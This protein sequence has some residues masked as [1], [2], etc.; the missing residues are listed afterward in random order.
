LWIFRDQTGLSFTPALWS[1][2]QEALDGS[3]YFVLMASPEAA[4]SPWVNR[5]IEHW[6]ATKPADRILP[7]VTDGEWDWNPAARD[8]TGESTAVPEALRGVFAEE[9]LYLDLRWA[10]ADVHL[11][12]EH[13]RFRDAIAQLAAPMHGVSKDD[14]EGEDV[15]QHR[16]VRRLRSGAVTTL[17]LLALLASIAGGLAVRNAQHA[18]VSA[19]EAHRQQLAAETQHG[20]AQQ[21]AADAQRQQELAR[22]QTSRAQEATAETKRQEELAHEQKA[23]SDEASAEAQRSQQNAVQ[24]R[25]VRG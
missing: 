20:L 17:V 22:Q 7:V 2:I 21:S 13:A 4:R 12:L 10:R 25:A 19:A 16:R 9:P 1:S 23:L 6:V 14:L 3:D 11:S 15:R 24:Q 18:N 8:S 5:E